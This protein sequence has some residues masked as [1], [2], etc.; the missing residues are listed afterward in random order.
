LTTGARAKL[1]V[2]ARCRKLLVAYCAP[3]PVLQTAKA[4]RPLGAAV[5][6]SQI[7]S[8]RRDQRQAA[9]FAHKRPRRE[10][11]LLRRYAGGAHWRHLAPVNDDAAEVLHHDLCR[12]HESGRTVLGKS[13][14]TA[15]AMTSLS[16]VIVRSHALRI[17]ER[18]I[19]TQS[20]FLLLS[21]RSLIAAAPCRRFRLCGTGL[22]P[23]RREC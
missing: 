8:F 2:G 18:R 23:M 7:A 16:G 1:S 22:R 17:N 9:S 11:L 12:D 5:R 3:P 20:P 14:A 10:R 21:C 19:S 13:H 15:K 6:T 4:A